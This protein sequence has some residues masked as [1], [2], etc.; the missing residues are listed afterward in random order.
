MFA[1][2][3]LME[4][5]ECLPTVQSWRRKTVCRR[6][7]SHGGERVFADGAVMEE[8]DFVDGAVME[9]KDCLPTVQ[10]WRRIRKSV[11]RRRCTHGGERLFADDASVISSV[12]GGKPA[13]AECGSKGLRERWEGIRAYFKGYNRRGGARIPDIVREGCSLVR[14]VYGR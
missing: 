14:V 5:K 9:E 11:C 4:E 12:R 2:G 1:D 8:K 13:C 10:S 6:R 3:A 7:C